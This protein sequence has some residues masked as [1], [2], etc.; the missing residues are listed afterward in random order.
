MPNNLPSTPARRTS[1]KHVLAFIHLWVG[2]I[3]AL[4]FI[5]LGL[6]GSI[7]MLNHDIPPLF[8]ETQAPTA[9]TKPVGDI[10]AAAQRVV[11]EGVTPNIVMAPDH[12]GD[13]IVIRFNAARPSE[14]PP[15]GGP[16]GAGAR[17]PVVS[18]DPETLATTVNAPP[19]G[20]GPAAGG[21]NLQRLMHDLHGRLLIEGG[22]G[23]KIVGWLGVFMCFLG[24]SGLVMWWPRG[25]AWASA[26][27]FKFGKSALKTN[28]DMHGAV[29]IW[30]LVVFMVVSFSGA[31]LGF[32]Q[33]IAT[34][35]D[36]APMVRDQRGVQLPKVAP[37]EGE[38]PA[39]VDEAVALAQEKVPNTSLWSVIYPARPDAP[40]RVNLTRV[41]DSKPVRIA[42]FVDHF[43]KKVAEVRDPA[44]LSG[45][46]KFLISQR[47]LH[48]GAG[49]GVVWWALVFLSGF[50]P[51]VFTVTGITMWWLKRRNK[52]RMQAA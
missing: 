52:K 46:D 51:L 35:M 8:G 7:L 30:G 28:R 16:P 26:F 3:F 13:P 5:A 48:V 31:Y 19:A 23:R 4:P 36:A 18:I 34:F 43:A 39:T 14:T 44:A 25:N 38:T 29:G 27:T 47:G 50:L 2:I 32:P 21:F 11:P 49:Y 1:I 41:D 42:V 9:I 40:F 22:I 6:T 33:Q 10:L 37:I 20:S 45:I 15:Q 17:G 24:I 12:A